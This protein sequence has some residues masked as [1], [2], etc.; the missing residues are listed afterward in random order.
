MNQPYIVVVEDE[1]TQRQLL[2]DYLGKHNFRVS[3]ADGGAALRR[4]VQREL[5]SLVLLD[6]GLPGEDGFA[7]ARWLRGRS[8]RIGIIMVT[9]ASDTVDRVIGLET[10]AD[11]Y[12][13]KPFE[14]R[15]L[16]ARVKSVLRRAI[17]ADDPT[18]PRVRMG[19][20][21]LDLEK[22]VLV[23]PDNDS[24]HALTA[25]EFDLLKV[26]AENP[27]RPLNRDWLMEVVAGREMEAFDRAIDLRITRLRRKIEADPAHPAAIRTVRGVGYMF[28]PPKD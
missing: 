22:R 6:V 25:S 1:A 3:G 27:N 7:L 14:P 18:Q 21:I 17:H 10:G 24:E 16:L 20:R 11:D 4:L 26:F 2:L 28:V 13:A 5:P 12:I 15:E 19:R 9:A 23:D 8:G